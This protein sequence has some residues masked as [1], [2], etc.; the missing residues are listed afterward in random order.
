MNNPTLAVQQ[1]GQSLWYDNLSR[2]MF[3]SGQ[4]EQLINDYGVLGV[5]TNPSIFEKAIKGSTLYDDTIQV[6]SSRNANAI[7]EAISIADVQRAANL[8]RPVY[9]STDEVDGYLSLA[10]PPLLAHNTVS[11]L[12]EARRL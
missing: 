7:F 6:D 12:S 3:K 11:T 5:T 8:F 9:Q 1:C 2:D 10:V 4:L